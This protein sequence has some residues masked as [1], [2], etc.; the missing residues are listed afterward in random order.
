MREKGDQHWKLP[1]LDLPLLI[2][3][4]PLTKILYT[5]NGINNVN[6]EDYIGTFHFLG[7]DRLTPNLSI[8][9]TGLSDSLDPRSL[10]FGDEEGD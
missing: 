10:E 5:L 1:S 8:L 4:D 6:R 9:H 2:V 3:N 7:S